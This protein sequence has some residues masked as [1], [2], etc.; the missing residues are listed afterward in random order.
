MLD[1]LSDLNMCEYPRGVVSMDRQN[2]YIA[3][4]V[5]CEEKNVWLK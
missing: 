5:M 3:G 4:V 1:G 2:E